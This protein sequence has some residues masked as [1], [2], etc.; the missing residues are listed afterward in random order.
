MTPEEFN[1]DW[2]DPGDTLIPFTRDSLEGIELSTSAIRFLVGA[3]LPDSAAPFLNFFGLGSRRLEPASDAYP[4]ASE[5]ARYL[6]IGFN[7]AGDP[8]CID[9]KSNGEIVLLFHDDNFRVVRLNSSVEKLAE[10]LLAYR[11]LVDET[12]AIN[13]EDAFLDG[14]IPKHLIDSIQSKLSEIDPESMNNGDFWPTE[15]NSLVQSAV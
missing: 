11:K 3:G 1:R 12:C 7:D 2:T 10:S 8:I 9:S 13:G 4:L 5:F 6:C 15:I 14:D